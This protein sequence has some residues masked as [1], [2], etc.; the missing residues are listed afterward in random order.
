MRAVL[1]DQTELIRRF[2]PDGTTTFVNRA[3]ARYF[4]TTEEMVIGRKDGPPIL[5]EDRPLV[6]TRIR[7]LSEAR[8]VVEVEHRVKLA[9]GQVRWLHWTVRAI[10]DHDGAVAEIQSVGR[11]VTAE[12]EPENEPA[13]SSTVR[14]LSSSTSLVKSAIA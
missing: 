8:P 12:K 4:G 2:L 11:D 7:A 1:Q 5:E 14:V 13:A 6:Q 9:N 3:Y 10:L